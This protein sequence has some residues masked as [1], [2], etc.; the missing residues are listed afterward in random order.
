VGSGQTNQSSLVAD[1]LCDM[2]DG[3]LKLVVF[4]D[5]SDTGWCYIVEKDDTVGAI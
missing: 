4:Y 5:G 3:D 2:V 1:F